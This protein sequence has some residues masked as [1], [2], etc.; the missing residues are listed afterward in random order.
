MFI[1]YTMGKRLSFPSGTYDPR[2]RKHVAS[3]GLLCSGWLPFYK[4]AAPTALIHQ[5]LNTHPACRFLGVLIATVE[6]ACLPGAA[7]DSREAAE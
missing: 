3:R 6:D 2:K 7:T 4:H 1:E 5:T